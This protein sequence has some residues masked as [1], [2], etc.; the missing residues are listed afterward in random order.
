MSK[1]MKQFNLHESLMTPLP[2]GSGVDNDLRLAKNAVRLGIATDEHRKLLYTV[3]EDDIERIVER[4]DQGAPYPSDGP[5]ITVDGPMDPLPF[6]DGPGV[7]AGLP[8]GSRSFWTGVD[9]NGD[10][11][12]PSYREPQNMWEIVACPVVVSAMNNL[13]CVLQIKMH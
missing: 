5:R 8:Q 6:Q 2:E 7:M 11:V 12:L 13:S 1:R 9:E 4:F 10:D 3:D